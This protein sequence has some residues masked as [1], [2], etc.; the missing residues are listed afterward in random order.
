MISIQITIEEAKEIT[1]T[2]KKWSGF[3]SNFGSCFQDQSA[4][5][6]C[7][8]TANEVAMMIIGKI[9][10]GSDRYGSGLVKNGLVYYLRVDSVS[11]SHQEAWGDRSYTLNA[12]GKLSENFYSIGD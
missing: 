2:G 3:A 9:P 7:P 4:F 11:F 1:K 8:L 5:K 10:E 12:E 6:D